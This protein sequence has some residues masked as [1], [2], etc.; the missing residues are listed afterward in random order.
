[1]DLFIAPAARGQYVANVS[2]VYFIKQRGNVGGGGRTRQRTGTGPQS[3]GGV[4]TE[5]A[6]T[7]DLS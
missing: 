1:M 3:E 5:R 2:C 7:V 6:L 4:K